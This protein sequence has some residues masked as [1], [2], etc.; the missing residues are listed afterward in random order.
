MS[1]VFVSCSTVSGTS[2]VV[3]LVCTD[4]KEDNGTLK[5]LYEDKQNKIYVS[6]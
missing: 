2:S 6:D 4:D 3:Y 1:L 5:F